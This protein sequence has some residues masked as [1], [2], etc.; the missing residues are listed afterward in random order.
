[1]IQNLAS[2]NEKRNQEIDTY[3]QTKV[4]SIEKNIRTY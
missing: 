3:N 1:M 4:D 2:T